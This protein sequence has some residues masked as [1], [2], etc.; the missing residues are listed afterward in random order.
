MARKVTFDLEDE[1]FF[2][3]R[4]SIGPPK[5][6]KMMKGGIPRGFTMSLD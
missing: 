2:G 6:D 5:F 1:E 3:D 4:A